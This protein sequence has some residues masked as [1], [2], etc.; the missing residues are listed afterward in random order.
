MS[1]SKS[2]TSESS[3]S[4][5]SSI[6]SS[7]SS[8]D[9]HSRKRQALGERVLCRQKGDT[10]V[11]SIFV[12][13]ATN[14]KQIRRSLEA[15]VRKKL[16]TLYFV[17]LEGKL[18]SEEYFSQMDLRSPLECVYETYLL[19][20]V[21]L[22]ADKIP[23]TAVR[24]IEEEH[25]NIVSRECSTVS[26][27]CYQL[28]ADLM[29]SKADLASARAH[30]TK[31]FTVYSALRGDFELRSKLEAALALYYTTHSSTI[32]MRETMGEAIDHKCTQLPN[33][34]AISNWS[35]K[36][37]LQH[38]AN[39]PMV[40]DSAIIISYDAKTPDE[41]SISAVSQKHVRDAAAT[42]WDQCAGLYHDPSTIA[43]SE[44]VDIGSQ[45]LTSA[46]KLFLFSFL[47]ANGISSRIT[48]R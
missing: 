9:T 14:E 28:K 44:G 34:M 11:I 19:N 32:A 38:W 37:L 4:I 1:T 29:S 33:P 43:F 21:A 7:G 42:V 27:E 17:D 8:E 40:E 10:G 12:V 46:Q 18:T 16:K 2:S 35:R 25:T 20:T 23:P 36:D 31:L 6:S 45:K 26:R 41:E 15:T 47:K 3:A 30:A 48:K 24:M 13:D 22:V 39:C 5:S